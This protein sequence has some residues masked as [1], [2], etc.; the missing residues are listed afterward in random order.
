M[1]FGSVV[2][3]VDGTD[4]KNAHAGDA[5]QSTIVLIAHRLSELAPNLCQII[6]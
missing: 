2:S 5:K 6:C 4:L 3:D 1:A